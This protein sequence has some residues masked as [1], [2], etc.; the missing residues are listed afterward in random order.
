[1][2]DRN[3]KLQVA[4][5]DVKFAVAATGG[6]AVYDRS[7]LAL[8]RLLPEHDAW[9]TFAVAMDDSMIVTGGEY[10]DEGDPSGYPGPAN[11]SRLVARTFN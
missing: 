2:V 3:M 6:S 8:A 11:P 9:S 1:M 5:D 10:L 4:F 7:S